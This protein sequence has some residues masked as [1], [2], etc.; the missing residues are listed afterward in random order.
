MI[1]ASF[2][3]NRAR[4]IDSFRFPYFMLSDFVYQLYQ[5]TMGIHNDSTVGKI[6]TPIFTFFGK[7]L[8][9]SRFWSWNWS[10]MKAL[11]ILHKYYRGIHQF[12]NP[13]IFEK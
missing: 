9:I 8:P 3:D 7:E 5:F 2:K 13:S 6:Y 11:V 4:F 12:L 1:Y 10:Q